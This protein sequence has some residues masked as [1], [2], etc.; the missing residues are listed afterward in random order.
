[1]KYSAIATDYDGTLATDGSVTSS[2]LE[3][4]HRYRD[5]GGK[6]ILVTGR[7]LDDL[8][9]VFPHTPLFHGI[10]AENGAVFYHPQQQQVRLLAEPFPPVFVQTLSQQG[11]V[12]LSQGRVVVATWQPHETIVQQT[13]QQLNLK[14]RVILNKRAVM[15]LPDGVNKASGLATILQELNLVAEHVVGIGDA[16]NDHSLLQTCGHGVAVGNA[17]PSLKAIAHRV[18]QGERGEGVQELIDWLL[19]DA[20]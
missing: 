9:Q 20:L 10:V 2:T 14:A 15:V 4:L 6:L 3:A 18:T 1:M 11:V 5:R 17:L 8:L 19:D 16:E 12:P 7:E 13:I